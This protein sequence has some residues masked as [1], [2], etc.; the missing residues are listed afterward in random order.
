MAQSYWNSLDNNEF[1]GDITATDGKII[2]MRWSSGAQAKLDGDV[3]V[4]LVEEWKLK[5]VTEHFVFTAAYQLGRSSAV[6]IAA[7]HNFTTNSGASRQNRL[8]D[9]A[10]ITCR[11]GGDKPSKDVA[12][13]ESVH[14]YLKSLGTG[15]DK[16]DVAEIDGLRVRSRK[17]KS[18]KSALDVER[19]SLG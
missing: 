19:S 3:R 10:H 17:N 15:N 16:F 9:K 14:V 12:S 6:V 13:S 5:A 1:E 2:K 11:L 7:P 4:Q 8:P 18:S